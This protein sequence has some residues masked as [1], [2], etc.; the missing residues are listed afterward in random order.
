MGGAQAEVRQLKLWASAVPR[1]QAW[2]RLSLSPCVLE[3]GRVCACRCVYKARTSDASP[4]H[5]EYSV[6]APSRYRGDLPSQ[7][8]W[9]ASL[10]FL[11]PSD[12]PTCHFTKRQGFPEALWPLCDPASSSPDSKPSVSPGMVTSLPGRLGLVTEMWAVTVFRLEEAFR[13]L[14]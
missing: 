12:L 14:V 9:P 7:S 5:G 2:A 10:T 11:V 6:R 13:P 8:P 4:G 1:T 3:D